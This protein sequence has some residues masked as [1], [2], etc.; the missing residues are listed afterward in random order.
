[1]ARSALTEFD[2]LL[3]QAGRTEGDGPP[4][5]ENKQAPQA[6][7]DNWKR[8]KRVRATYLSMFGKDPF[9]IRNDQRPEKLQPG[10][11][12]AGHKPFVRSQ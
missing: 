6:V 4:K 7:V 1:M 12:A 11:P 8:W 2:F 10:Q 3:A 5:P 9:T